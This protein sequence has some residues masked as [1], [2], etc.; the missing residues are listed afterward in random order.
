MGGDSRGLPPSRERPPRPVRGGQT[1]FSL[2]KLCAAAE[3][4]AH[5]RF[6]VKQEAPFG[7][8]LHAGPAWRLSGAQAARARGGCLGGGRR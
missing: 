5:R 2:K 7:A 1:H 3:A 6:F 4:A 8:S